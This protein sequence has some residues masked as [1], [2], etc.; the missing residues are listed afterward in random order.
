[1]LGEGGK[2]AKWDTDSD[3]DKSDDEKASQSSEAVRERSGGRPNQK[4]VCLTPLARTRTA[5][6]A[7]F[8]PQGL[9]GISLHG[10]FYSRLDCRPSPG[11]KSHQM[12]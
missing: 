5:L 10:G 1:M 4:T 11:N 7:R 12:R 3:S 6:R 2:V 9:L 8:A